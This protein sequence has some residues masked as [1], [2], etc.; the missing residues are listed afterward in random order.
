MEALKRLFFGELP[1]VI[2]RSFRDEP[3]AWRDAD[4]GNPCFDET[5]KATH[6]NGATVWLANRSYGVTVRVPGCA[7]WGDV[8]ALSAFGLSPGH[9]L[10]WHHAKRW[11]RTHGRGRSRRRNPATV[12]AQTSPASEAA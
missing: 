4:A 9:H 7:P 1:L 10:I 12:F 11:L 2:A 6:R 3:D 5:Y 8:T